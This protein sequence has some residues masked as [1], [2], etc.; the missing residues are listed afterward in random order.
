VNYYTKFKAKSKHTN[1]PIMNENTLILIDGSS[2][3]YRAFHA[4]P[5]LSNSQGIPTGAVYGITTML[6]SL[7]ATYQPVYAA[8]VFDTVGQT[9]RD[10]LYP[11]YKANRP[12]MP[13][14]LVKQISL[15][16]DLARALGFPVVLQSGVEADDIIGTFAKQAEALGMQVLIFTGD[17]D[18]AQLVNTSITLIDTM[19]N[20]RLDVQGV[21]DKF[22]IPPELIVDYL[23]LI[24]DTADNIPGVHQVGPKTAVKWLTTYGSLAQLIENAATIT[25]KVGDNLRRALP[26]IPLTRQLV[27]LNCEVQLPCAPQQLKLKPPEISKLRQLFTELEFQQWLRELPAAEPRKP[28]GLEASAGEPRKPAGLEA[29]AGEPRKPAGLE[30]LAGRHYHTIL[31]Q[32]DF[33]DWLDR[34]T[35]AP[36]FAV[37]TET[38]GLDYLNAQIVGISFAVT[39][40]EAAYVPLA[41]DYLGAPPQLARDTVLTTL[42]PLLENPQKPKI[43]QNLKYD[44]HILANHGIHLQGLAYD[45]LLESYVL[46]STA[47]HDMDSL[48]ARHLNLQTTSFEDLAGKGKKQ[49]SFNQIDLAQ[50]APYAAQDADVTWQL[51]QTLWPQLQAHPKLRHIFTE[52]EMPLIPV[53]L[54]MERH[55]VK[56]DAG[57]LHQ[58]SLELASGLQSLEQLVHNLAGEE[59]NLNSP[60]QLQAILFDKLNLPVLKRTKKKEPSTDVD[61]LEELALN[62][63]L[64]QLILEYRSLSKLKST[65]TDALPQQ[66]H[67]RTG[68]VHTSYHQAVT[69]TG[70]LSSTSPNL[71][72]IPIRTEAGR[73]IRQAFVAP[74]GYLLLAADYSQIELRI[75]AHLSQD[76]KLLAAFAT[77]EDIHKA[78]AAEVFG[79]PLAQVTA[80]QRRQA[81][82]INFG[83][84]YGMQAFGLAK[85]LGT[86]RSNAQSYIDAYFARYSK[87]KTFMDTTREL[88]RQQ[89]YVET[90]LGRRLYIPDIRSR[91]H[92]QRQY[93]ERTAI[94]AP[95]QGTAADIIKL[96]MVK[97]DHWIQRCGLDIKMLMQVH[98][99]LV[100]EVAEA[101]VEKAKE[102][103]R[104]AMSAAL[105]LSVPL[106]VDLGVG[107]N[108]EEAH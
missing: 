37:D 13:D 8:I 47:R 108:W 36:L 34:L 30:A 74:K 66:I 10:E 89:G 31:T 104:Q 95:M 90:V 2:Y 69:A 26:Q 62:Y 20:T 101:V 40:G 1:N 12:P 103:I 94:N 59:F 9:F 80:E 57:L 32:T 81:K 58:Q 87:V 61:V 6:K 24:G 91:H 54:R 21:K 85:Q 107:E 41:H 23:T 75:M 42:K 45:T 46:D 73:R 27:T 55:G 67:P 15:S 65:Y 53:L 84:I 68:R 48:A 77:G 105:E 5:S 19:K 49:L 86:G 64:P 56:I 63:P 7:L 102:E 93:A 82:A 51:H 96:A 76:R 28:A 106:V 17:K 71:Q 78:T 79:I 38:T 35:Q 72:N 50:A 43:G 100:F 83:L 33:D 92:Q 99:E 16:H 97:I 29:L 88:A 39:A 18:F 11:D 70:R 44:A 14:E 98:D 52:L 3:L 60:K 4:L 22:G 25:G